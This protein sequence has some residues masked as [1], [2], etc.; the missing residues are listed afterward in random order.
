MFKT[1]LLIIFLI[2][3]GLPIALTAAGTLLTYLAVVL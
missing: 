3:V 1:M 2:F